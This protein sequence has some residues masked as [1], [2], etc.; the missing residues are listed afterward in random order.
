LNAL[1]D[2]AARNINPSEILIQEIIPGDGNCQFSYCAFF[3]D[4]SV[5][6]ALV[7]KHLRQHPREFGRAASYVES[8]D[9]Q[10]IEE[11]SQ[12][13]LRALNFYGL[14]E[15][16]F[17]RDP[18]DGQYKLLDV[19][20]RAWG[21]HGLGQVAGVDFPYLLFADQLPRMERPALIVVEPNRES[22]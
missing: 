19:N 21:F 14:V 13:F 15:V 3:R 9:L 17:K 2:A 22:E 1:F 4:G 11:L 6:S 8:A 12:R 16:E 7:A 10:E 20:V 18:R 5:H